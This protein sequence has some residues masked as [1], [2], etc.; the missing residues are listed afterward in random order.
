MWLLVLIL[1]SG[2]LGFKLIE[3]YSWSDA[4]YMTI[5][6]VS[7]VGYTEV[8]PLSEA[9]KTF[10]SIFIIL[11]VGVFAYILSVFSY[12]VIEG[13]IF[14]KMHLNLIGTHIK[15]L[16]NHVILCGYGRY[17]K[18]AATHFQKHGIP[19]VVIEKNSEKITLI[20]ES[21][22]KILYLQEDATQDESLLEAGIA[23]AGTLIT[24]L[25][26]DSDNVFTVLTARQLNPGIDIISVAKDP[27]SEKKL[28]LAGANHVVM[29]EQIGGFYMATLVT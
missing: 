14:K 18:E 28:L 17:G 5:I 3:N 12:F 23:K 11:N 27:K 7:T 21:N 22:D 20:Q 29:P 2:I 4:L 15:K 26:E 9:G 1:I 24:A 16:S 8:K 13:E 19:F 25:S 10:T 6:T